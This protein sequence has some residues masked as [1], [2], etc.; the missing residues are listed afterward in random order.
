MNILYIPQLSMYNKRTRGFTPEA[1]GNV[2]MLRNTINEWHKYYPDDTFIILLPNQEEIYNHKFNFNNADNIHFCYYD[3]YVVSS[4][5]NRFNFPMKEIYYRLSNYTKPDIIINDVI[6]IVGNIKQMYKIYDNHE[7][8]IISNIRHLDDETNYSYM[9]R[10]IDGIEQSDLVTILSDTMWLNLQEQLEDLV[11]YYR[12]EDLMFK[13]NT[14]EPSVSFKELLPYMEETN[15]DEIIITFPG[16]LSEGEEERTNWDKFIKAIKI[17]RE[18]RQDF[19]V[20]FTDPNNAMADELK[21]NLK[22]WIKIIPKNRKKFLNLL[23]KTDIIVS[24]M[25][26]EGFGGISPREALL[27]NCRPIIPYAHEYKK[28]QSNKYPGFITSPINPKEL[29]RA[30]EWAINNGKKPKQGIYSDY[31]IKFTVER[32]FKKLLPKLE[33]LR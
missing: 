1:D 29:A 2:N 25:D 3:N 31:G 22:N 11:P 24:L 7:P 8:K 26:K 23:N 9:Y 17:V 12:I 14:F 33:E 16:R 5:I 28:M 21:V 20:Y 10:V 32:Q 4:R 18:K 13:V 6:E 15:E 27:F 19:E 30:L